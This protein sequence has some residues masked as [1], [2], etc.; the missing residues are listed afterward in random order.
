MN[1]RIKHILEGVL[2]VDKDKSISK[3]DRH[4]EWEDVDSEEFRM[5]RNKKL[6]KEADI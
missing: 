2:I 4:L 1:S 6:K 3:L 5:K